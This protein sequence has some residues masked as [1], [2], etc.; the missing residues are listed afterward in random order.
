MDEYQYSMILHEDPWVTYTLTREEY[1]RLSH[2]DKIRCIYLPSKDKQVRNFLRREDI[3]S[4]FLDACNP[5]FVVRDYTEFDI[6]RPIATTIEGITYTVDAAAP[7]ICFQGAKAIVSAWI[8]NPPRIDLNYPVVRFDPLSIG[9]LQNLFGVYMF[10]LDN[11]YESHGFVLYMT[12]DRITV[13]NTYGG[14]EGFFVKD[15]DRRWWLETFLAFP[16]LNISEQRDNYH[17]L[18]GFTREM[19]RYVTDELVPGAR[20]IEYR[21]LIYFKVF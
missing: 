12:P 1:D 8:T 3:S 14:I 10:E 16:T 13:Y 17:V 7:Y 18:W 21:S 19:V 5:K 2:Y 11:G 20:E 6:T 4:L 9:Q 15:F